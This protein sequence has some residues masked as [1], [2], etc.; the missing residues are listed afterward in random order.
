MRVV[1][2]VVRITSVIFS[3]AY[4]IILPLTNILYYFHELLEAFVTLLTLRAVFSE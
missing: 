2:G 3:R 1:S 4:I